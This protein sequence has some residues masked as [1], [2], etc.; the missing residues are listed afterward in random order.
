MDVS[1]RVEFETPIYVCMHVHPWVAGAPP[2]AAGARRQGFLVVRIGDGPKCAGQQLLFRVAEQGAESRVDLEESTVGTNERE[3]DGSAVEG[4]PAAR[5]IHAG[6]LLG[7][8]ADA[9]WHDR[10]SWRRPSPGNCNA[11]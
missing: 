7:D 2:S 3:S 4:V 8:L 5:A 6:P 9:P 1:N 11:D 10:P